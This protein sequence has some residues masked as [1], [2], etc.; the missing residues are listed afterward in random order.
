MQELVA[1]ILELSRS[2]SHI[3]EF[4]HVNAN[5][6][7]GMAKASL[8]TAIA[9]QRASIVVEELPA[10]YCDATHLARVFQNLISNALRFRSAAPPEVRISA[11]RD[12]EG[13]RFSVIDNG[14][15]IAPEYK[16]RIFQLFARLHPWTKIPG[17]GIGLAICKRIVEHHGGKIWLES[18]VGRGS[19]FYFTLPDVEGHGAQPKQ[20][21]AKTR[22]AASDDAIPSAGGA[23]KAL[24]NAGT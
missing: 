1:A 13:W 21:A 2:A 12:G 18:E 10:V 23:N 16:D 22:D 19:T 8:S 9:E 6:C 17:A 20:L 7:L 5:L 11:Y 15:G 4:A 14:I 24:D 3:P